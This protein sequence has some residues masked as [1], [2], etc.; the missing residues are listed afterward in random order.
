MPY[1]FL[2][3]L[4][5][6]WTHCSELEQF[7]CSLWM[8]LEIMLD[9][10]SLQ[11]KEAVTLGTLHSFKTRVLAWRNDKIWDWK[12]DLDSTNEEYF[13]N[14]RVDCSTITER[15]R[16]FTVKSWTHKTVL[17]SNIFCVQRSMSIKIQVFWYIKPCQI[18]NL[19]AFRWKLFRVKHS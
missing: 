12:S 6:V 7:W 19:P 8:A 3:S 10:I 18:V 14:S 17:L 1:L 11:H 2:Q 5:Q 4:W 9:K 15:P 16:V 13:I